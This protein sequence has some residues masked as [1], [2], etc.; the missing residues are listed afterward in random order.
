MKFDEILKEIQAI[1]KLETKDLATKMIKFNEEYGEMSAE[2]I[3]LLGKSYKKYSRNEL[4]S[5]M[6]DTLQVLL[7]VFDDIYKITGI[8]TED[9]LEEIKNKNI[10]WKEKIR[11][12]TDNI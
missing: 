6:A 4:T 1:N 8:S 10:K 5:E 2:V 3:K 11:Q 12:Y 7:A 9:V